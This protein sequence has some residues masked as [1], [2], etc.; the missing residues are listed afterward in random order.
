M[1]SVGDHRAL[2]A[3][4]L[5][6]KVMDRGL[7][8]DINRSTKAML[9]PVWKG[10]VAANAT[11]DTDRQVIVKGTRVKGG[12]P[13]E[14]I[15]ASSKRATKGGLV[16]ADLWPVIEFGGK[17]NKVTTYEA[18]SPKGKRH[19]VTRRTA[20]QLPVRKN[21]GRVAYKALAEVTPRVVSLWVSMIVA[22]T[23]EAM[24]GRR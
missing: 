12:N 23:Y 3:A 15:A 1:L 6:L 16:P 18:T 14:A 24:D 7:R 22:K 19:S 11:T 17:S 21:S 13:P 5:A 4:V 20:R 10:A 8:S 9:D 2:E